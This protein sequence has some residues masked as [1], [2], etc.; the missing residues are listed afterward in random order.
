VNFGGF[1]SSDYR[2]AGALDIN[3]STQIY[4][5]GNRFNY[6][7]TFAPRFRL[8]NKFSIFPNIL[9]TYLSNE[10]G[11]TNKNFISGRSLELGADDILMGI[12]NRFILDN[13][14]TVRWI[15]TN[16][17]GMNTRIRHYYDNVQYQG[18]GAL[19]NDGFIKPI[20][21]DGKSGDGEHVFDRNINI[22]NIDMQLNWRFLPG[23]DMVFV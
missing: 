3:T 19:K 1:F 8:S 11:F 23:S 12:R 5:Q 4:S 13:T 21:F 10:P 22:F 14:F 6:W 7:L 16:K 20:D 9:L 15:F 2:K 18:F 17:I